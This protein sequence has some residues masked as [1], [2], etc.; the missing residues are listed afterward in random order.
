M[1][2]AVETWPGIQA[3]L[4]HLAI[5]KLQGF[6]LQTLPLYFA[7]SSITTIARP[8]TSPLLNAS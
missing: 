4:L 2:T 1:Q 8:V 7:D 5:L 3:S 6:N